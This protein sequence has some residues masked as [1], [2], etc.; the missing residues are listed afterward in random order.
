[1]L[2]PLELFFLYANSFLGMS[3]WESNIGNLI[4]HKKGISHDTKIM[5][6]AHMDEVGCQITK[7]IATCCYEFKLLGSIKAWNL[8]NQ[9]VQFENGTL[10]MICL[11]Q[12]KP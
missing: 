12:E 10:G 3:L 8:T 7:K 2:K 9:R 1:M 6:I 11:K 4:Y 5:I